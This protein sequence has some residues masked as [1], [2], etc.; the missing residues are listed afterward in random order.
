MTTENQPRVALD[1]PLGTI[2]IRVDNDHAPISGSNFL[3]YVDNGLLDGTTFFRIVR[4]DNQPDD[5]TAKIEVVQFGHVFVNGT[6]PTPLPA[7]AHEPTSVT[8]LTHQDGT[9][10]MARMAPGTASSGFF[11]CVGDQPELDFGGRRQPDGLGFAAF[12][13]VEHGMDVVRKILSTPAPTQLADNPVQILAAN[14]RAN[15]A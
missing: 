9:V 1:T 5:G 6:Y 3:A 4:D 14:R 15:G 7:I 11:I 10:S 2:V 13:Q 12:G 8:G